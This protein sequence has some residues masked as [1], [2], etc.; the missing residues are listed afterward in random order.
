MVGRALVLHKALRSTLMVIAHPRESQ[1]LNETVLAGCNTADTAA[2]DSCVNGRQRPDPRAVEGAP[3]AGRARPPP[4]LILRVRV[5][6]AR[7][8]GV[9]IGSSGNALFPQ[10]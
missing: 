4:Q 6:T 3:T 9:P 7:Q 10:V 1:T 8:D 2:S 5:L